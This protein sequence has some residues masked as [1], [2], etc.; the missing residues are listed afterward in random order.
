MTLLF[1]GFRLGVDR[2]MAAPAAR[3]RPPWWRSR[4]GPGT[5]WRSAPIC[6]RQPARRSSGLQGWAPCTAWSRSPSSSR[7]AMAT[8]AVRSR[9]EELQEARHPVV[10]MLEQV[11]ME[12]SSSR[13][14]G[15]RVAPEGL[16]HPLATVVGEAHRQ[17]GDRP[18]AHRCARPARDPD[19]VLVLEIGR[20]DGA[21]VVACAARVRS[22]TSAAVSRSRVARCASIVREA[23]ASAPARMRHASRSMA[24]TV[25]SLVRPLGRDPLPEKGV[26]FLVIVV[27]R[28]E[29]ITHSVMSDHLRREL[30][31]WP[32]WPGRLPPS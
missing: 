12:D 32:D 10:D 3:C 24:W 9:M 17:S 7:A 30:P 26:L 18:A 27:D 8:R 2:Q 14:V 29:L 6:P 16:H 21:V 20:R 22:A 25:T 28:T 23:R 11:A 15:P 4:K 13:A 5:S 1:E 31:R 19:R